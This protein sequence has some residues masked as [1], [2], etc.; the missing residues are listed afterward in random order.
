MFSKTW[1]RLRSPDAPPEPEDVVNDDRLSLEAPSIYKPLSHEEGSQQREGLEITTRPYKNVRLQE[2]TR[3]VYQAK[4]HVDPSGEFWI[5]DFERLLESLNVEVKEH[6]D[7]LSSIFD[8]DE[9]GAFSRLLITLHL[10][11]FLPLHLFIIS[12]TSAASWQYSHSY[13]LSLRPQEVFMG[14][15]LLTSASPEVLTLSL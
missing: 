3:A 6:L 11:H 2:V 7:W 1:E 8:V 15:I 4:R 9:R 12:Y 5:Q 10:F 13:F 14:L